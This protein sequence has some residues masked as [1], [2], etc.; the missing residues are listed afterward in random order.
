MILMSLEEYGYYFLEACSR[1][2]Y[3]SRLISRRQLLYFIVLVV[4]VWFVT[5]YSLSRFQFRLKVSL[6]RERTDFLFSYTKIN[7]VKT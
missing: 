5:T 3:V 6:K 7:T 4:Y 2:G 1:A